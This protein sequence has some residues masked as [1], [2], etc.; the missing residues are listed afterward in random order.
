MSGHTF[1]EI[2]GDDLEIKHGRR[3]WGV[4]IVVH[5]RGVRERVAFARATRVC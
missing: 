2:F 1:R 3:V 4:Q 5:R